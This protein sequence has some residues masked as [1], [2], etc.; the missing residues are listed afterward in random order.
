MQRDGKVGRLPDSSFLFSTVTVGGGG[1]GEELFSDSIHD[2]ID[3]PTPA[4]NESVA[5]T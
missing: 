3:D 2:L 4:E 1:G 5:D